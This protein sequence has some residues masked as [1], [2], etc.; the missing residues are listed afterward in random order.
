VRWLVFVRFCDDQMIDRSCGLGGLGS[1]ED[2]CAMWV[3]SNRGNDLVF[4]L[5]RSRGYIRVSE[6]VGLKVV[7]GSVRSSAIDKSREFDLRYIPLV[8]IDVP[9]FFV[10]PEYRETILAQCSVA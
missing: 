2:V 4:A 1:F 6:M 9:S 8:Y 5:C 10:E 7:T 3:W